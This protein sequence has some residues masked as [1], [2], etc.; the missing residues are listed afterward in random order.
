MTKVKLW[1]NLLPC[2]RK[3][4]KYALKA[5]SW[6]PKSS[7][8]RERKK[9]SGPDHLCHSLSSFLY[10]AMRVS[11][12]FGDTQILLHNISNPAWAINPD[13]KSSIRVPVS[14]V[15]LSYQSPL[16]SCFCFLIPLVS[17]RN[18]RQHVQDLIVMKPCFTKPRCNLTN[19]TSPTV[20]GW[21]G[22]HLP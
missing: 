11:C 17:L 15:Y 2:A 13:L 12:R 14:S 22:V 20:A 1:Q 18:W 19:S 3:C 16:T 7:I 8:S 9:E 6:D 10:R 5:N 4:Y 21:A